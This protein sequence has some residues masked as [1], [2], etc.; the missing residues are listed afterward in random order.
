MATSDGAPTPALIEKM[1]DLAKG[2][3]GLII[4][5]HAYVSPEGQAVA[6]QLGAYKDEL[7]PSLQLMTEVVH[8]L[9][10][11]IVMQ[12]SHAGCF[13][14]QKSTGSDRWVV[15]DDGKPGAHVM[16]AQD[17]GN[18]TAAFAE[19]ARRAQMAGFDGVQLHSAHGYLLSQFLSP[20]FNHR[21]DDYGGDIQNRARMVLEVCQAVRKAVGKNYP[22][23]I[24]LNCQDFVENGLTLE[25]SAQ[26]GLMLA[27]AGLDAIELSGGLLTSVKL[28]PSR[29]AKPSAPE[30][31]YYL[32]EAR[33]FK[34]QVSIPLILVGGIRS[35]AMSE[36]I[37]EN[38]I[39]DYVAMSRPFIKDPDL[40]NRW[41]AG[42]S[43]KSECK[44][45][46]RCFRTGFSGHGISCDS[47]DN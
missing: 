13:A 47:K 2:G 29:P 22:V 27:E 12:L 33:E 15:S 7:I 31:P 8:R 9:G 43:V 35:L 16:T 21:D 10:G 39:A 26:V 28:S 20:V 45:D 23:L 19:G 32:N 34:K 38:G 18:I 1:E 3:V 24:K 41:K 5:S 46:N 6:G 30:E 36:Y 40:I 42:Q 37:L 11:K 4:S 25:D 17:I 44:S 14:S